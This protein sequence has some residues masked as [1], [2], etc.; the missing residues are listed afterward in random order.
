M[1]PISLC[2]ITKNEAQKLR[3]CLS[4]IKDYVPEIVVVDTGSSDDSIAVAKEFTDCVYTFEWI[5]DFA[6]ARNFSI[7]KAS[8][9]WILVLDTDEYVEQFDLETTYKLMEENPQSVGRLLRF[10]DGISGTVTVDRVERLFNKTYYHYERPIHEQVLPIDPQKTAYAEFN[11]PLK[12]QHDGYVGSPEDVAGKALR[13][14]DILL[15][16]VKDYPDSYTYFQIAQSYYLLHDDENAKIYYEKG[17]DFDLNPESEF[18][19]IMVVNYCYTLFHLNEKEK[20]LTFATDLEPYF[21]NYGD[22][23]FLLGYLH[24]SQQH[25]MKAILSFIKATQCSHFHTDGVTTFRAYHYLGTIYEAIGN[26]ELANS[27]FQKR[28]NCPNV[29]QNHLLI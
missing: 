8:H 14:L 29:D 20:A 4:C 23:Q 2:I 13:N 6:A 1:I 26:Q 5:K 3:K 24:T 16:S 28:D 7:S 18:V 22:F 27:F 10:S 9:D 17:L 15:E 21:Q 19:Q 11:I 12:C 25:I